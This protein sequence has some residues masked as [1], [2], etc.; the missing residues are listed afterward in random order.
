MSSFSDAD[1]QKAMHASVR[2][3]AI[4]TVV[5]AMIVLG[6]RGWQSALM[7]VVGALISTTGLWEWRRLMTAVAWQMDNSAESQ[8]AESS[9]A[10]SAGEEAE[11]A[12]KKP[13][14]GFVLAVFFLRLGVTVAVLY[15]TLK[16]LQGSVFALAAG[17]MVGILALLI[18]ALRLLRSWTV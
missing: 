16:Y 13:R 10:K 11:E 3:G 12:G 14:M 4:F 5:G 17:L 2:L 15:V 1:F 9:A 8:N 7:F 18:Q 6:I